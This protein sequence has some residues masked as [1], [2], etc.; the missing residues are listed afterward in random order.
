MSKRV[1]VVLLLA[2]WST[3]PACIVTSVVEAESYDSHITDHYT[4]FT[5]DGRKATPL[6]AECRWPCYKLGGTAVGFFPPKQSV[7]VKAAGPIFPIFPAPGEGTSYAEWQFFVGLQV[8]PGK[9]GF[10]ILDPSQYLVTIPGREETLAPIAVE[11]CSGNTVSMTGLTVFGSARCF[12]LY[13]DL[14]RG[15]AREFTLAPAS[16]EADE[17]L[18]MFPDVVWTP[19]TYSWAE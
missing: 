9:N 11:D 3:L 6:D 5:P 19:G 16:I 14:E 8:R 10:L 4:H 12:V 2:V 7:D 17:I 18:Y 13:Y 15:D 1:L